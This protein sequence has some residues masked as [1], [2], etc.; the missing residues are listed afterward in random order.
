MDGDFVMLVSKRELAVLNSP[1]H[2]THVL[3]HFVEGYILRFRFSSVM[4]HL[5]HTQTHNAAKHTLFG[6]PGPQL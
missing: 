6:V 1:Y 2:M 3:L 4:R 5:Q